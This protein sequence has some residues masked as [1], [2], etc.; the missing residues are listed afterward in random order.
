MRKITLDYFKEPCCGRNSDPACRDF[1]RIEGNSMKT[2]HRTLDDATNDI[3]TESENSTDLG[4]QFEKIPLDFLRISSVYAVRF[5][6]YDWS[7]AP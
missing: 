3:R 2:Q 6:K 7:Y 5:G 1:L 4:N